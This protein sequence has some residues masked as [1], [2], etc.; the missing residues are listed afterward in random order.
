MRR[1]AALAVGDRRQLEVDE[2]RRARG[3]RRAARAPRRRPPRPEARAERPGAA[4]AT[5]EA[6][7]HGSHGK[8]PSP[9]PVRAHTEVAPGGRVARPGSVPVRMAEPREGPAPICQTGSPSAP[10]D[11][12][13]DPG[14]GRRGPRHPSCSRRAR[15]SRSR[16]RRRSPPE[17]RG[18]RPHPRSAKITNDSSMAKQM[19]FE[20]DAREA[21]RRG[22][23][24]LAKAVTSTLGPARPQR[25]PRQGLGR[26]D[27]SPRTASPSPRRSSSPIPT[28][29]MGA[30]LVKEVASKT[31]DVAGDGTTTATLLT[32]AIFDAGPARD[33]RRRRARRAST[34]AMHDGLARG[35]RGA[36]QGSPSR[37]RAPTRSARSR[38]SPPTTTPRIGKIIADAMDKVGQRRRDHR[39]GRQDARDR[40]RA[41]S[42]ACS[43]TAATSRR[44]SSP[45]P[46]PWRCVFEKPLILVHEDKIS[47]VQK[48]LPL[49]ETIKDANR[50]LLII[51]E[52]VECEALATLVVNKLRGIL[53]CC[54]VKA[55]GYGDRRKAMLAGHRHR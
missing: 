25:G 1:K 47:N 2:R 6:R 7:A 3:L 15:P 20:A 18:A 27:R 12:R 45:T 13:P 43:S 48:L 11:A 31:S 33:H 5:R 26:P 4:H 24:K 10:V 42:R 9:R 29:S 17:A 46:R 53:Q 39:R 52:D 34:R 41:S 22:V 8:H 55:P 54:A 32:E 44:T 19:V 35:R 16:R 49:L 21:I 51:A 37:S 36:R 23:E 40:R 28:S 30:Q 38:R 50:P 14:P